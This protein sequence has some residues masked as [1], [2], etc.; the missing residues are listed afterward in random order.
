MEA[1]HMT[2]EAET[3]GGGRKRSGADPAGEQQEKKGGALAERQEGHM[4]ELP[5]S[6]R[7][8]ALHPV[9]INLGYLK[10]ESFANKE[11]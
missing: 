7:P 10:T 8:R 6:A 9:C 3:R 1:E 2:R 11:T 5:L 4:N